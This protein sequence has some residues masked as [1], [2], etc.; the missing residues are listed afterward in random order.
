MYGRVP[1]EGS[2]LHALVQ[3]QQAD[4]EEKEKEPQE[5]GADEEVEDDDTGTSMDVGTYASL[6]EGKGGNGMSSS[7]SLSF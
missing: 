4:E 5:G 3:E 6:K 1:P 7:A 2:P